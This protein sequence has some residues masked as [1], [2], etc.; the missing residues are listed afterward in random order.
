MRTQQI[1]SYPRQNGVMPRIHQSMVSGVL[2]NATELFLPGQKQMIVSGRKG[3][4]CPRGKV[5]EGWRKT[6]KQEADCLHLW[7]TAGQYAKCFAGENFSILTKSLRIEL[8]EGRSRAVWDI[9]PPAQKEDM[10]ELSGMR[11]LMEKQPTA[12]D[13]C[14]AITCGGAEKNMGWWRNST[15]SWQHPRS[16][17]GA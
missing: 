1:P 14:L 4:T 15:C 10:K 9:P 12:P 11:C 8:K 17:P 13:V 6:G 5:T 16:D 2:G 7:R 3:G